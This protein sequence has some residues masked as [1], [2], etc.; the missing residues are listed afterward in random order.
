[1][2][3]RIS[4]YLAILIF[5]GGRWIYCFGLERGGGAEKQTKSH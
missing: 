3:M 5:I 4:V 2:Y 1:M